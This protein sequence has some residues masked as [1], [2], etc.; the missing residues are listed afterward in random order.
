[1]KKLVILCTFCFLVIFIH[2][3][4]GEPIIGIG[5]VKAKSGL[6]LREK[7]DVSSKKISTLRYNNEVYIVEQSKTTETIND[8][9][10]YWYRIQLF[11]DKGWVF[12]GYLTKLKKANEIDLSK[13]LKKQGA[14]FI[15]GTSCTGYTESEWSG[16]ISFF[17]DK[18]FKYTYNDVGFDSC[19][20]KGN[21]DEDCDGYNSSTTIDIEGIYEISKDKIVL[22]KMKIRKSDEYFKGCCPSEYNSVKTEEIKESYSLGITNCV[23]QGI[24]RVSL[25]PAENS[26]LGGDSF[27]YSGE[28]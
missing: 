5:I 22:S 2:I 19:P 9:N 6:I 25:K 14:I 27:V 11:G 15:Q 1:M 24:E 18:R 16:N 8:K 4:A 10:D 3:Y 12:G 26:K 20:V 28:L 7:P 21:Y 23:F 13:L 17:P